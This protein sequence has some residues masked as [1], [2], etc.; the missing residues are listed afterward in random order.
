MEQ[1]L[2]RL[3]SPLRADYFSLPRDFSHNW[4]IVGMGKSSPKALVFAPPALPHCS[5]SGGRAQEQSSPGPGAQC[6][7]CHMELGSDGTLGHGHRQ[8]CTRGGAVTAAL[9]A[10]VL[11]LQLLRGR[12]CPLPAAV[13]GAGG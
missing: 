7:A 9:C 3:G 13:P 4:I 11:C 1:R 10:G 5:I 8:G 12:G 6:H 2:S